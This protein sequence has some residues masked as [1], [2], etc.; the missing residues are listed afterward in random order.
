MKNNVYSRGQRCNASATESISIGCSM[1]TRYYFGL[2][3]QYLKQVSII[4]EYQIDVETYSPPRWVQA[5]CEV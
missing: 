4:G 1:V 5:S 2:E 3:T